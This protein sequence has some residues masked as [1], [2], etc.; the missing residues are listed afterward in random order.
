VKRL[1]DADRESVLTLI[2]TKHPNLKEELKYL[3]EL[4]CYFFHHG[5]LPDERLVIESR[6]EEQM[7][8]RKPGDF[9]ELLRPANDCLVEHTD[10]E[11][12]IPRLVQ[13]FSV[14]EEEAPYQPR[15]EAVVSP[16]PSDGCF[17]WNAA[18]QTINGFDFSSGIRFV[19]TVGDAL[20]DPRLM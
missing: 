15:S 13:S 5:G 1:T 4:T 6:S 12:P 19:G 2:D 8:E 18:S 20:V 16:P 9:S 14:H 3:S 7:A 17:D 11:R 10:T